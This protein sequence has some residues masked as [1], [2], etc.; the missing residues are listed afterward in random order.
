MNININTIK[1][2]SPRELLVKLVNVTNK[3]INRFSFM[4]LSPNEIKNFTMEAII[5]C[6]EKLDSDN[7]SEL[8]IYY[9]RILT[10]L[11]YEHINEKL[12]DDKEA[13]NIIINYINKNLSN[14]KSSKSAVLEFKKITN[15]FSEYDFEPSIDLYTDLMNESEWIKKALDLIFKANSK[16][17]V[18]NQ[19]DEIFDNVL[20]TFLNI[21]CMSKNI[22]IIMERDDKEEID[23]DLFDETALD[24]YNLESTEDFKDITKNSKL[25][26]PVKI[27]LQEIGKI[28][29]LKPEEEIELTKELYE[30]HEE[31]KKYLK[32][33][34]EEEVDKTREK[35]KYLINRLTEANLRLVVSVAKKHLGKGVSLLDLIQ[36]G[37]MGLIKA[38]EKFDYT[39]GYKISTYA[40]WWIRQ[41]ITRAIADQGRTI[42]IP[43]HTV[44]KINRMKIAES[45]L[46]GLLGRKPTYEELAESLNMPV[47]IVKELEIFSMDT[48]SFETPIGED[49]DVELGDLISS[50][51]LPPEE[52]MLKSNLP[53]NVARAF[54]EA[55]LTD[56]ERKILIMRF[57]LNNENPHTLEETGRKLGLTRE[58]IRQIEAKAIRKLRPKRI[59]NILIEYADNP[60]QADSYA[61]ITLEVDRNKRITDPKDRKKSVR[62]LLYPY[63][64]EQARKYAMPKIAEYEYDILVKYSGGTNFSRVGYAELTE[65][66][67]TIFDDTICN[68]KTFIKQELELERI[69]KRHFFADKMPKEDSIYQLLCCYSKEDIDTI[70]FSALTKEQKDLLNKRN[71]SLALTGLEYENFLDA[72][73]SMYLVLNKYYEENGLFE[74]ASLTDVLRKPREVILEACNRLLNEEEQ[75]LL[76]K[77]NGGDLVEVTDRKTALTRHEQDKIDRIVKKLKIGIINPTLEKDAVHKRQTLF[78]R[79]DA[80]MSEIEMKVLP[81]LTEKEVDLLIKKSGSDDITIISS[82]A[83]SLT[84]EEHAL[85]TRI[86]SNAEKWLEG[87]GNLYNTKKRMVSFSKQSGIE[88]EKLEKIARPNLNEYEK[89]LLFKKNG[90]LDFD[91]YITSTGMSAKE[92]VDYYKMVKK[93]REMI[94]G[95]DERQI[96]KGK[97]NNFRLSILQIINNGTVNEFKLEDIKLAIYEVL[98]QEELDFINAYSGG[99]DYSCVDYN[100]NIS[101]KDMRKLYKILGK[102]VHQLEQKDTINK[103]TKK[104][105]ILADILDYTIIKVLSN[106]MSEREAIIISLRLRLNNKGLKLDNDEIA[107]YLNLTPSD[108]AKITNS[109]LRKFSGNR[110]IILEN[111]NTASPIVKKYIITK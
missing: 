63:T 25:D 12:R 45:N 76:C 36:E 10:K 91:K 31:E 13:K 88:A 42:R 92:I 94:L 78:N 50:E 53:E 29:L 68:I 51:A 66:E 74:R 41:A 22:E 44:E 24:E 54:N 75:K 82:N 58:R 83:N 104:K 32:A 102:V 100:I 60:T 59:R 90:T 65:N 33:G 84:H 61:S 72:V 110:E 86:I 17:I 3:V 81:Y 96:N 56:R 95:A 71:E 49:D 28:P 38:I 27:Y 43:V 26:D 87:K 11:I 6:Q 21:Y 8:D 111:L 73:F 14:P 39:R 4:Q 47:A 85:S 106:Y 93:Y 55:K 52:A 98:D 30:A 89:S 1:T 34:N 107:S 7:A 101:E 48:V 99:E 70:G 77:R 5:D 20:A 79:L 18:K 62:I 19:A 105:D 23:E 40:V 64:V 16:K 69:N 80:N 37:N 46:M 9:E 103:Q 35:I 109:A 108:V 2:S 15:F 97:A 57:G 67:K